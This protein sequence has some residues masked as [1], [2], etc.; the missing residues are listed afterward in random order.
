MYKADSGGKAPGQSSN[1]TAGSTIT[2]NDESD[3][4]RN[5]PQLARIISVGLDPVIKLSWRP[6]YG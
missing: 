4:Q 3:G 6:V 1:A 5:K 2:S